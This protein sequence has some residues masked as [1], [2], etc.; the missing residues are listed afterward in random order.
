MMNFTRKWMGLETVILT[1]VTQTPKT[2]TSC[3]LLPVVPSFNSS[4]SNLE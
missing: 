3:L 1:E 2:N 4:G